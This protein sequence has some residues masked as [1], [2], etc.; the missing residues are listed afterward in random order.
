[1][2]R[3]DVW[4]GTPNEMGCRLAARRLADAKRAAKHDL[5]VRR[6]LAVKFDLAAEDRCVEALDGVSALTEASFDKVGEYRRWEFPLSWVIYR[7][8]IRRVQ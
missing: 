7:L 6:G 5:D 4:I 2:S 3:Y 1:M 8:E